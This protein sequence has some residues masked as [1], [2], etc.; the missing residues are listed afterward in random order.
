MIGL[1]PAEGRRGAGPVW[2]LLAVAALQVVVL[3]RVALIDNR[4]V[5]L[6]AGAEF[7]EYGQSGCAAPKAPPPLTLPGAMDHGSGAAAAGGRAV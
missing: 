7:L 1:V 2:L 6:E 4:L 3:A 5:Q